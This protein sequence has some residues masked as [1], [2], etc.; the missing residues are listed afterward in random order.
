MFN[1]HSTLRWAVFTALAV[2]TAC[3]QD[4]QA[5][6]QA[7][8]QAAAKQQAQATKVLLREGGTATAVE[9]LAAPVMSYADNPRNIHDARLWVFHQQQRPVALLKTEYMTI[10]KGRE[11]LFCVASLATSPIEVTLANGREWNSSQPGLVWQPLP[12]ELAPAGTPTARLRQL[13]E[14]AK[15]FSGTSR[16]VQNGLQEMRLLAQ[17]L[18]RYAAPQQKLVDAAIFGLTN[19]GTNPDLLIV[20][21]ILGGKEAPPTWR[22]AAAQMTTAELKLRWDDREVWTAPAA[23]FSRGLRDQQRWMFYSDP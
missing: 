18:Y 23:M 14:L 5:D 1:F 11:W 7:A 2:S 20:L 15:R 19:N 10:T 12:I 22:F 16:D 3:A 8:L 6:E 9:L 4:D 13:R 21:E 17:P